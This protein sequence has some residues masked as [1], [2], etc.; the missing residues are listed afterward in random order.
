MRCWMNWWYVRLSRQAAERDYEA[1]R[2]KPRRARRPPGGKKDSMSAAA[3][4]ALYSSDFQRE[5]SIEDQNRICRERGAREVR[6][7]YKYYSDHG[8]RA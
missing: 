5:A 7:V 3:I 6:S 4:Y 8:N 1:L 2:N